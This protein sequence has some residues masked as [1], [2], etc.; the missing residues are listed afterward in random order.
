[1]NKQTVVEKIQAISRSQDAVL[2]LYPILQRENGDEIKL[3]DLN[4]DA[5]RELQNMII[6]YLISKFVA[7]DNLYFTALSEADERK[8][9]AYVYD[10]DEVPPTLSML[11]EILANSNRPG[12]SFANDNINDITGFVILIGDVENSITMYKRHH[13]LSTMKADNSFSL[14]RA[15]N[16]F[17]KVT[18]D[19]LKLSAS[20]DFLQIEDTLIATNLKAL[21]DTFGYEDV[22]RK[23]AAINIGMIQEM[24]I[25]EDVGPLIDMAQDIKLAKKIL[26][27]K[28]DSP[29]MRLPMAT[30]V[31]FVSRHK[32]IMKKFRLSPDGTRLKLD[33]QVS[34]TLFLALMN[35]DF[36]TS[37]LTKLYYAGL[38]KDKM[39]ADEED[40]A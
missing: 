17:I 22:I 32:P 20:V 3:A 15:N 23:Q 1:M 35:D 40:P 28:S 13:H 12:F 29:V 8:N 30:V 25:L 10:L 33:T 18:E 37:E 7:N 16:R 26:K 27:I 38:S 14:F 19:I 6:S 31:G 36:L 5:A 2:R 4:D 24:N 34:K 39:E 21:E 11:G 9:A